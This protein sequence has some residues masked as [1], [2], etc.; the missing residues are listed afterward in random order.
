MPWLLPMKPLWLVLLDDRRSG[1]HHVPALTHGCALTRVDDELSG[2]LVGVPHHF[3][4]QAEAR[5]HVLNMRTNFTP[6]L[7]R[8]TREEGYERGLKGWR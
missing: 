7:C 2:A 6:S 4:V 8:E 3:S 5:G 1:H